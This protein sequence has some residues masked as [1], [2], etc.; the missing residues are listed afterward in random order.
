MLRKSFSCFVAIMLFG[1]VSFSVTAQNDS[2]ST[3]RKVAPEKQTSPTTDLV[4]FK[5]SENKK[6]ED[7]DLIFKEVF[8]HIR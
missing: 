7:A 6:M 4:I 3:L 2:L 1:L 8:K 5:A